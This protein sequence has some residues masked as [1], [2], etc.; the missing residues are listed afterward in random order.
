M[1]L[2]LSTSRLYQIELVHQVESLKTLR[3]MDGELGD[4]E[5]VW[6]WGLGEYWDRNWRKVVECDE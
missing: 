5:K 6:D 2:T 1:S 4:S 3:E